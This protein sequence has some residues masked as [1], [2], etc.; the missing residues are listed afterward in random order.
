MNGDASRR[1]F[2]AQSASSLVFGAASMKLTS[3]AATDT[4]A[5]GWDLTWIDRL[6][7]KHRVVFD[8]PEIN[9]GAVFVNAFVFIGGFREVYNAAPG[10][11]HAV[12]VM[13]G[14]GV[15]MAFGDAMWGKYQLAERLKQTGS[16]NP[17]TSQLAGLRA[18][19]AILLACNLAAT[20]YAGEIARA[21]NLDAANVLA[22]LRANMAPGVLLQPSGVFATIRAQQAGCCFM[23]SA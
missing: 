8:S 7:G 11:M 16:G 9:D 15:H 4:R 17:F 14:N 22:D 10:D 5:T 6:T 19:G 3:P 1:A 20:F 23:K 21:L 18:N 12:V 13:R 2:I